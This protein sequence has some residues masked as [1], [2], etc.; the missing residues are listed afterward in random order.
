MS[1][2]RETGF[3]AYPLSIVAIFLVLQTVRGILDVARSGPESGATL[4]IHSVLV[5]GVLGACLGVLGTLI[6]IMMAASFIERAGEVSPRLVWGGVRVALGSSV[7]GFLMLG[8]AS[9]AWL[10]LQYVKGRRESP[11]G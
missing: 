2:F 11:I 3:I 1:F 6:G 5:L 9:I 7:V 8:F 10:A 4:R